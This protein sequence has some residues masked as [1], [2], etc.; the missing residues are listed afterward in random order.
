[1]WGCQKLKPTTIKD[2]IAAMALFRPAVMNSGATD[3][4]IA[5]KHGKG[6]RPVRHALFE[7]VTK[8]TH[9][10]MLY[11]EQVIDV[12]RGLGM[13]AD[14]LTTFLKAVKASNK[15]IGSAGVVIESYQRWIAERCEA[16]GMSR[17]DQEYLHDAIAGFAEYG[18]N[19]AH[20]TVYGI[21][22][23]RARTWRLGIHSSSTP[24]SWGSQVA[25]RR[26]RRTVTSG[27]PDAVG[28]RCWPLTSTSPE[29]PTPWTALEVLSVEA[30]RASMESEPSPLP[31]CE[32]LQPFE[33]LDDLVQRA[34]TE[35][36]SGHKEYDGTPESLTGILGHLYTS[37]ALTTLIHG[38]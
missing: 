12:L 36:V 33:D 18:F 4:Y 37:G 16:V 26:R 6:M 31:S 23:Y 3:A 13:G 21:T 35:T 28:S 11:Q 32:A 1:M 7:Q 34:A 30:F 17:A 38:R 9:G 2:V 20:A 22:A 15:D 27:P 10:I 8:D 29:P 14:D 25:A 19:R 24:R 5:R